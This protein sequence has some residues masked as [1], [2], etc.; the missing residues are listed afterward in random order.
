M[1][2][3]I[4]TVDEEK[5]VGCNKCIRHCLVTNANTAYQKDGENKVS[6]NHEEC[7][8]CGK[9]IDVCDHEARNFIYDTDTFFEDLKRGQKIS[10][11]VAPSIRNNF[12][13]YEN[14]FGFLISKGVDIIYDVSFGADITTW[15]YLMAIQENKLETVI[16]QPCPVIVSY[17][18]KYKPDIINYLAPVHSPMTCT[19][20]YL[21]KH[22]NVN[23]KIAFLSPC[24]AKINEINDPNTNNYVNYNVTY[25]KLKKYIDDNNIQLRNYNKHPFDDIGTSLGLVF[26]RP[27]GLKEN[28]EDRVKGAWVRQIEGHEHAYKYLDEYSERVQNRKS[29]PLLVDILNC[30]AGC[31]IGTATTKEIQIDDADFNFNNLKQEKLNEK[32][33]KLRQR[34]IDWLYKYFDKNLNLN[35]YIRRYT[36]KKVKELKVPSAAEIDNTFTKMHKI[37]DKDQSLN[38]SACGNKTCMEMVIAINNK[39][40]YVENC[41][42]YNKKEVLFEKNNFELQNAELQNK[43]EEIGKILEQVNSLSD[44]RLSASENLKGVISALAKTT[45]NSSNTVNEVNSYFEKIVD[46]TVNVSEFAKEVSNSVNNF[47][48]AMKEISIS[49]NDIS[50]NCSRSKTITENAENTASETNA[51]IDNLNSSSNQIAKIVK[52]IDDIADQTNMLALNAAIEAAGAGEAGKGFAVVADEVKELAK[53]TA[54]STEEI[55]NQIDLMQKSITSAV[56]AMGTISQVIDEITTITN[57][58]AATISEQSAISTDISGAI[59]TA[60]EKVALITEKIKDIA[61][62][63]YEAAKKIGEVSVNIKELSESTSNLI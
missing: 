56:T 62:G 19:A 60:A 39:L 32:H 1:D 34:R 30:I 40:S 2:N 10:V 15:A 63:S 24:I 46:N 58:I 21:R 7:L 25:K 27:G 49:L 8:L 28:V 31:N 53:Q 52:V 6:V 57:T 37:T 51:I 55:G 35:D 42:D 12:Y 47:V 41:Q 11:I 61:D 9:C 3:F 22:E 59:T 36:A 38:C 33:G 44:E 48:V 50:K 4:I 29:V 18:E 23:G 14:L 26:S 54:E 17:I 13:D 43:N 20:I 45:E 16:A 5:C